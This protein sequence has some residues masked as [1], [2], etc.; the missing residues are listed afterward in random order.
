MWVDFPTVSVR[1]YTSFLCNRII[2]FYIFNRFS[3]KI[4]RI[5]TNI[6]NWTPKFKNWLGFRW[7]DKV[8]IVTYILPSYTIMLGIFFIVF[9]ECL[10]ITIQQHPNVIENTDVRTPVITANQVLEPSWNH[11]VFLLAMVSNQLRHF[12]HRILISWKN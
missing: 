4:F 10:L 5:Q 8:L 11:Q 1:I 12:E 9:D 2:F 3:A 7:Y 6:R